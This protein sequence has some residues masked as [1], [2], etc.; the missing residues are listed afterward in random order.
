MPPP[1]HLP[2]PCIKCTSLMSPEFADFFF[3]TVATE[4]CNFG[5]K[6][7][8]VCAPLL[9]MKHYFLNIMTA[10]ESELLRA[11]PLKFD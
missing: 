10:F 3:T 8:S 1:G 6:T 2:D 5:L 11:T 9:S 7:D 4:L